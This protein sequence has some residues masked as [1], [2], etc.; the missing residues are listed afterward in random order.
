MVSVIGLPPLL[1]NPV[2]MGTGGVLL[3]FFS[4]K[5]NKE[6]Y[7][8]IYKITEIFSQTCQT[9]TLAIL[10]FEIGKDQIKTE[11]NFLA[12]LSFVLSSIFLLTPFIN[13]FVEGAEVVNNSV[14]TVSKITNTVFLML[15]TQGIGHSSSATAIIGGLSGT[16]SWLASKKFVHVY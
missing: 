3:E 13:G 8:T 1:L 14:T 4:K 10:Y 7:P 15:W 16:M 5:I 6:K 2:L 11:K 9:L 12:A